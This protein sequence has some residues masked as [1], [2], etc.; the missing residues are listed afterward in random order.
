MC[1]ILFFNEN[2]QN[3]T[4]SRNSSR[5]FVVKNPLFLHLLSF[6]TIN[7]WN[8]QFIVYC[9]YKS[10][11]SFE[12]VFLWSHQ[13]QN[14][15]ASLSSISIRSAFVLL[16]KAGIS[17]LW[18]S[19]LY[20]SLMY[21]MTREGM[22]KSGNELMCL[23]KSPNRTPRQKATL[24]LHKKCKKSVNQI[25]WL[26]PNVPPPFTPFNTR[27]FVVSTIGIRIS[28]GVVA[29]RTEKGLSVGRKKLTA[30]EQGSLL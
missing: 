14:A 6:Q 8:I 4:S 27:P 2:P 7:P 11:R 26:T 30:G 17:L 20:C 15:S 13:R 29:K 21:V 18:E 1:S 25:W 16:I 10:F 28:T 19:V 12:S 23:E 22:L 5:A 24:G 3:L 9:L